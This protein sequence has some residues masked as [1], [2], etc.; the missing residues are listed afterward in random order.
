M[1][2]ERHADEQVGAFFPATAA[3]KPTTLAAAG[4][5]KPLSQRSVLDALA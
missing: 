4:M 1:K 2:G 5:P 3:T